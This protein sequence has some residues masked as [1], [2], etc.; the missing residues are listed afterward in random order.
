MPIIVKQSG[1]KRERFMS[2]ENFETLSSA[3]K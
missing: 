2:E 3:S 1:V